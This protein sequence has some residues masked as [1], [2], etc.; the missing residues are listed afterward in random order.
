MSFDA[1]EWH[2][3]AMSDF[4]FTR[5]IKRAGCLSKI[6]SQIYDQNPPAI[7]EFRGSWGTLAV[8]QTRYKGFNVVETS[9]CIFVVI[10]GPVICF[11]SKNTGNKENSKS[12][13]I[14]RWIQDST[15]EKKWDKDLS[16]PFVLLQIDKRSGDVAVVTD[17]L[18]LIPVF[19]FRDS[20]VAIGTHVDSLARAKSQAY[21]YDSVSIADFIANGVVTYPYTF[22]KSIRQ[23]R[24]G[25]THSY[26]G[27]DHAR[28]SRASYWSPI[29]KDAFLDIDDAADCLRDSLRSYVESVTSDLSRVALFLS[30]GEDS[31]TIAAL[32]QNRSERDAF[33]FLDRM[34]REGKIAQKA[35][36]VYCTSFATAFRKPGRYVDVLPGSA[37]LVGSGV[38]YIQVH[39][40]G[41]SE[42][43]GLNEYAAVFDGLLSDGLLKG[44][45]IQKGDICRVLPFVP[46]MSAKQNARKEKHV[47]VSLLSDGIQESVSTRRRQH[48][49]FVTAM[50]PES[51]EEWMNI[52][53]ASMDPDMGFFFGNRRLMAVYVPFMGSEVIRIASHVPQ[54]WKLNRR[55]FRRA[56]RPFLV[57]TK[58]LPHSNGWYPYR[59][60]LFNFFAQG[61]V[62]A[63]RK[64]AS[65]LGFLQ[66]NQGPW[67]DFNQVVKDERWSELVNLWIRD[68]EIPAGL[69]AENWDYKQDVRSADMSNDQ[70]LNLLQ[71]IYTLFSHRV[72]L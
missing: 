44:N 65:R 51:A 32:L 70:Y 57:L 50:R 21:D 13:K 15:K 36:R 12:T 31:R 23:L 34:N 40:Y 45:F 61:A 4:I 37:R 20:G 33:I 25:S 60:I 28:V 26:S 17:M 30:G 62:W 38:Q 19:E 63:T 56:V 52:W 8:S 69:F 58:N 72:A 24:P 55:L 7:R 10:G 59:G 71:V 2:R 9:S 35:A 42:E 3:L 6:L 53:P 46:Q 47:R 27:S 18:S 22:Y 29:E 48:L 49:D 39:S 1:G 41:F 5:D 67:A 64:S 16:G 54:S 11:S 68:I 43:L 66:N 14:L